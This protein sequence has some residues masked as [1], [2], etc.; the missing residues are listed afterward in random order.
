M[1][2]FVM[3]CVAAIVIAIGGA[4]ALESLQRPAESAY[5][6]TGARI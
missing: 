3:A 4:L 1:K 5:S 2:S 6:T